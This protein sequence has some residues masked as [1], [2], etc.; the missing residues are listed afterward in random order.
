MPFVAG[1]IV[2]LNRSKL[3]NADVIGVDGVRGFGA[4]LLMLAGALA[5]L[6]SV[7]LYALLWGSG[8]FHSAVRP[9]W[10]VGRNTGSAD[11]SRDPAV[12]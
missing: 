3:H 2:W 11:V 8:V 9:D 4:Q 10:V 12:R 6:E 5:N 7:K 1:Y